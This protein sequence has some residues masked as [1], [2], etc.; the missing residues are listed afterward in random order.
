MGEKK[1]KRNP[2]EWHYE[3]NSKLFKGK[4]IEIKMRNSQDFFIFMWPIVKIELWEF[5]IAFSYIIKWFVIPNEKK[6]KERLE[7]PKLNEE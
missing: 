2:L 5:I 6:K 1:K 7:K 3:S 4:K